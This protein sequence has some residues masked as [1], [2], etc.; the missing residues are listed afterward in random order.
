LTFPAPIILVTSASQKVPLIRLLKTAATSIDPNAKIIAGDVDENSMSFLFADNYWVMPYLDE[1][2]IKEII[3][4]CLKRKIN[5][6]L[7]TRDGELLFW[8]K[9]A[10][11][12]ISAGIKILISK[13]ESI[14]LCL[15]KIAFSEF[16]AQNNLPFIPSSLEIKDIR[17][18]FFVVKERYGSG[19]TSIGKKLSLLEANDH[20]KNL[21]MPLF[22]PFVEGVEISID[23]WLDYYGNVK[24]L[25]LRKRNLVISGESR[26]TTTFRDSNIEC[27][28]KYILNKLG[29]RGPVVMQG[30]IEKSGDLKIIEC[31]PRFGG[32][33]TTSIAVGLDSLKWSILE[34]LDVSLDDHPFIRSK[35]EVKQIRV[36]SDIYYYD[37]DL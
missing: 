29:L 33:S 21:V 16:G 8:A 31:N 28:A 22:Q 13:P 12:F 7:P 23:A 24:G 20:K 36:L 27:Q 19:S 4:E 2:I 25:V 10:S 3:Q 9:N 35:K 18:N 32:A 1:S 11:L 30:I 34:R 6:I 15:D 26:V 14:K 37:S 5:T 17:S